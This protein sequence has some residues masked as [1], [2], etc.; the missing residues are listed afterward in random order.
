MTKF[1]T[2]TKFRKL[3][4]ESDTAK[5]LLLNHPKFTQDTWAGRILQGIAKGMSAKQA[6]F[7]SY[8]WEQKLYEKIGESIKPVKVFYT[9]SR[10]VST[11]RSALKLFSRLLNEED[12]KVL[13][14]Q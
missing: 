13:E 8:Y 2:I 4:Q 5:Q 3:V 1:L 11:T 10:I 7:E 9:P 12:A 14:K 6:C